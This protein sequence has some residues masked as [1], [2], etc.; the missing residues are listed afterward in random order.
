MI[1]QMSVGRRW[2]LWVSRALLLA[3]LSAGGALAPALVAAQTISAM[4][5]AAA[6]QRAPEPDVSSA[7]ARALARPAAP[8]MHSIPVPA[9]TLYPGDVIT[10]SMLTDRPFTADVIDRGGIMANREAMLG[11]AARRVL[12]A[13]KPIPLNS[14]ADVT[15]V[16]KGVA[17]RVKLEEHGL[18]ISGF[19]MPLESGGVGAMIRLKNIDSSQII[20]GKIQADGTVR[21]SIQ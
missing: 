12:P 15:L 4:T 14:V 8:D 7:P 9:V 10:P 1:R 20:V 3:G 16:T 2:A 6:S 11:K 17:A 5:A 13:G 21:V 18:V 19:A